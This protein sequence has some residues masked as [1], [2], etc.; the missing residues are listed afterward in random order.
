LREPALA[1]AFILADE[2]TPTEPDCRTL[3]IPE[4][5]HVD[6]GQILDVRGT[7]RWAIHRAFDPSMQQ[8][9]CQRP[10]IRLIALRKVAI[11]CSRP[12]V[13]RYSFGIK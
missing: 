8:E 13:C 6:D 5:R 3:N 4:T 12:P 2:K 10:V 11:L 9:I 7:A 1:G